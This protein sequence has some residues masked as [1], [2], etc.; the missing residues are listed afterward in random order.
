MDSRGRGVVGPVG[1]HADE[2]VGAG[3]VGYLRPLDVGQVDIL[4]GAGHDHLH[5]R[6]AEDIAELERHG[7]HQFAFGDAGG[8][9]RGATGHLGLGL[10]RPGPDGLGRG[11]ALALMA[12]IYD[13]HLAR[14]RHLARPRR[15]GG[16]RGPAVVVGR[17]LVVGETG[18]TDVGVPVVATPAVVTDEVVLGAGVVV[19]GVVVGGTESVVAAPSPMD[20]ATVLSDPS[21]RGCS[22]PNSRTRAIANA[23]TKT[24]PATAA[25]SRV[26]RL[27]M[28]AASKRPISSW[29]SGSCPGRSS[30]SGVE[31]AAA[32]VGPA[33][34]RRS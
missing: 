16:G 4:S 14:S 30:I 11:I 10:R 20:P 17:L 27:R 3:L 34:R 2:E 7:K 19:E 6:R 23:R 22:D 31:T 13:Y 5:P 12:G 26:R 24:A 1:V 29:V 33:G 28:R 25:A 15:R 21:A 18:G 9:P 32:R 8:H